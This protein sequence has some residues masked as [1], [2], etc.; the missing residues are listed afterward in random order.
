VQSTAYKA[1]QYVI[2]AP[3][4]AMD[5]PQIAIIGFF[6]HIFQEI[7]RG[8][9]YFVRVRLTQCTAYTTVVYIQLVVYFCISQICYYA[10]EIYLILNYSISSSFK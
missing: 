8:M 10:K 2:Y 3:Q 7:L 1:I 6:Y 4:S 5:G 9:S